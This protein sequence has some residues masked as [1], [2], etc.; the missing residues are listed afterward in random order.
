MLI[1]GV[2]SALGVKGF[3]TTGLRGRCGT[4]EKSASVQMRASNRAVTTVGVRGFCAGPK[5][6]FVEADA[7]A[8]QNQRPLF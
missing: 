3:S 5:G 2:L 6:R 7:P 8:A 1:Q 4:S